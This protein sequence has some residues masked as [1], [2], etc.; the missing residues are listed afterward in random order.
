M[1]H[2]LDAFAG[3][4]A[5]AHA[6]VRFLA[7]PADAAAALTAMRVLATGDAAGC[8]RARDD[9]QAAAR[10]RRATL[11][12]VVKDAGGGSTASTV[13]VEVRPPR[14]EPLT[15]RGGGLVALAEEGRGVLEG[16]A[17]T[18][19]AGVAEGDACGGDEVLEVLVSAE[20]G[21]VGLAATAGVESSRDA[22]GALRLRGS[23]ESL[24][25]ALGGR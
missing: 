18:G 9:V 7:E 19:G 22:D 8:W 13:R 24:A 16:L 12:V 23:R 17:L 5:G 4:G 6:A 3:A 21:R 25:R 10:A 11:A 1:L 15:V 14:P 2:F 20:H